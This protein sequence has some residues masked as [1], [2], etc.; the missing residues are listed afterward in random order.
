MVAKK[1]WLLHETINRVTGG[2]F[3]RKKKKELGGDPHPNP[4]QRTSRRR[5]ARYS[6][7]RRKKDPGRRK[8]MGD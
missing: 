6:S 4:V 1:L 8:G 5:G 2:T 7:V 3:K